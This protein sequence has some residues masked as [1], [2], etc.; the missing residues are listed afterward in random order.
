MKKNQIILIDITIIYCVGKGKIL[1]LD[2]K[3]LE[4]VSQMYY[5][6]VNVVKK[7]FDDKQTT[8]GDIILEMS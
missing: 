4:L 6:L 1:R 5:I 2:K 8:A 7:Y 3:T